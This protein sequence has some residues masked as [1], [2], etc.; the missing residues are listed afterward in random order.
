MTFSTALIIY[1]VGFLPF[2]LVIGIYL[3]NLQPWQDT[4]I[5]VS[6]TFLITVIWPILVL[7]MILA[8]FIRFL[9][10]K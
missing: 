5:K 3:D 6:A 1:L 8:R 4:S 2:W 9:L 7:S 10:A